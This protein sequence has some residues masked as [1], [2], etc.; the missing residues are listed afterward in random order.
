MLLVQDATA[1]PKP[2]VVTFYAPGSYFKGA[3]TNAA[4]MGVG[5]GH[6]AASLGWIFDGDEQVAMLTPGRFV[7]VEVKPGEH[8]FFAA[9]AKKPGEKPS[10]RA[11]LT[12]EPGKHYFLRMTM[13]SSGAAFV[14]RYTGHLESVSCEEA[15][16]EAD[17]TKPQ[18]ASRIGKSERASV[19]DATYFPRCD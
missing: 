4:A 6:P 7:S 16:Q 14:Q 3:G 10:E 18:K 11:E 15:R 8:T 13:T 12:I 19:V 2:A 9:G 17:S 5:K 1:A